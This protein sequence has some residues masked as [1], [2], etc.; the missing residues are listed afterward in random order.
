MHSK[1]I[2]NIFFECFVEKEKSESRKASK[3]FRQKEISLH[4]LQK[5]K[6]YSYIQSFSKNIDTNK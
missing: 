4:P 2:D 3:I 6:N 5:I 1:R